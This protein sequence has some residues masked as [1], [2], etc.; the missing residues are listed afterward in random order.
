M[1]VSVFDSSPDIQHKKNTFNIISWTALLVG[2]LDLAAA[3]L[4][5]YIENGSNPLPVFKF[6]ASG[7]FGKEGLSGGLLMITWGIVFHFMISFVFTLFLF[8]IYPRVI[9]R[10]KNKFLTGILYGIG[11]WVVMNQV[12]LPV[13]NA[14]GIPFDF[15]QI[16]ISML[17]LIGTIGIPVALIADKHYLSR[18]HVS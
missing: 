5:F 7:L 9:K 18:N 11:I 6:I 1:M 15:I 10:L 17:I 12:V 14:P 8:L 4:K 16:I 13:S 2:I 3:T